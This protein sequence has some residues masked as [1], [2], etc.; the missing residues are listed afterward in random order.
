MEDIEKLEEKIEEI[1]DYVGVANLNGDLDFLT[2]NEIEKLDAK[3]MRL[4]DFMK[5]IDDK[6]FLMNDLHPKFEQLE[7]FL[8]QGNKFTS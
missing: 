4:D 6:N 5:V 3:C 7:N 2:K 8:K 1:E